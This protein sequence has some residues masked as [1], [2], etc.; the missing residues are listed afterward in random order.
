[1]KIYI[2]TAYRCHVKDGGG[3]NAAET[4]FF[5]GKCDAL[6]ECYRFVPE[7]AAWTREDGAVFIGE[8]IAPHKDITAAL[9]IQNEYDHMEENA[10][11]YTAAYEEGVQSA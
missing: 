11:D 5:D 9:A 2:D 6:I 3:M 10:G 1:M 4:D 7:G 8:M